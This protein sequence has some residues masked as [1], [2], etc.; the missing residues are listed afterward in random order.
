MTCERPIPP[1]QMYV[2]YHGELLLYTKQRKYHLECAMQLGLLVYVSG[3]RLALASEEQNSGDH[4][5]E[6]FRIPWR[7]KAC[8]IWRTESAFVSRTGLRAVGCET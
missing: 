4:L 5:A 6:G 8:V 7:R 2:E 3:A 1:G